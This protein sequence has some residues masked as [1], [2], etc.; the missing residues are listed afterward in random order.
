MD[1]PGEWYLNKMT[2]KLYY[3]AKPGEDMNTAEVIAPVLPEFITLQG[4]AVEREYV[5]HINFNNISFMYNNWDLPPGNSNNSQGSASVPACI[6]LKGTRYCTFSQCQISNIGTFAFEI[7]NG[8][9]FNQFTNNEIAHIAAGGFR[10][11]GGT[12]YSP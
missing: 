8:C 7:A 4:K 2:G 5:E 11:N 6:T 9:S 10:I 3:M 12:L 1:E